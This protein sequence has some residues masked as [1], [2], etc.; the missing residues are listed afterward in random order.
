MLSVSL[1]H[2]PYYSSELKSASTVI[3]LIIDWYDDYD[4]W[5]LLIIINDDNHN[6]REDKTIK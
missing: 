5:L 2:A 6:I 3:S 4:H 1:I